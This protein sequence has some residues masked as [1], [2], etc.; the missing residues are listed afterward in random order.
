MPR[1]CAHSSTLSVVC[2]SG[3]LLLLLRRSTK[4]EK[5]GSF[6]HPA[7]T[8]N[9]VKNSDNTSQIHII[10]RNDFEKALLFSQSLFTLSRK[11]SDW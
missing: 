11:K 4:H 10:S 7:T 2:F 1:E 5:N 9:T 8:V 6:Q 3:L